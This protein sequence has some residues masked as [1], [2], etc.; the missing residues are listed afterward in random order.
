MIQFPCYEFNWDLNSIIL[1]GVKVWLVFNQ[2]WYIG[3]SSNKVTEL[4]LGA[5]TVS[6]APHC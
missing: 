2:G 1:D 4:L 5:N 6:E 3:V